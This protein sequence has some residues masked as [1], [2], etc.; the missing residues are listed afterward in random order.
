M[1]KISIEI[2]GLKRDV[3]YVEV[4]NM[5]LENSEYTFFYSCCCKSYYWKCTLTN[6]AKQDKDFFNSFVTNGL[7]RQI[8]K[9]LEREIK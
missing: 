6:E 8:K 2:D 4:V 3:P 1:D 7:T 9:S 5:D